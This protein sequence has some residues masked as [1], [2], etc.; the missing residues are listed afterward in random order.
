MTIVGRATLVAS[1]GFGF[2]L[3]G[4]SGSETAEAP[5]EATAATAAPVTFTEEWTREWSEEAAVVLYVARQ[6]NQARYRVREQLVGYDLPNDAVGSTSAITGSIALDAEGR[7][8]PPRSRIVVDVTGLR[9]DFERR[10][11][12]VQNRLLFTEQN[13]TVELQPRAIRGLPRPLPTSGTH[14]FEMLADLTV[15]GNTRPTTWRGEARFGEGRVSGSSATVFTF[16][17]FGLTQPRVPILVSVADSIRL[18][19]DFNLT[20]DAPGEP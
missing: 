20:T 19:Y 14:P 12:Y 5:R 10:D 6:G 2:L 17:D 4:C 11:G 3:A 18:E 13:P 7:V 1:I 9:S 15:Q 8:I 16:D